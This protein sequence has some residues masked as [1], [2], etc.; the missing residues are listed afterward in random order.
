MAQY[1]QQT[2]FDFPTKKSLALLGG[3]EI[4]A[5]AT[6]EFLGRF[7]EDR[8]YERKPARIKPL[9]LQEWFSM[10]ANTP[11]GGLIA[12]GVADNGEMEGCS[13]LSQNQLNE[14]EKIKRLVPDA[15]H[16]SKRV[17]VL[18]N[19]GEDFIV[20]FRVRF[21]ENK[22]VDTSSGDAFIRL[23]GEKHLLTDD[24]RREIA[25]DKGQ[26]QFELEPAT[27]YKYPDDFDSKLVRLF[28]DAFRKDRGLVD[29]PT[30]EDILRM[31]HLGKIGPNGFEPNIAC[32]LLF[33]IDPLRL[34][35]AAKIQFIRYDGN[36]VGTGS[37]Y[38]V[39]KEKW[40]E[41]NVPSLIAEAGNFMESQIR[42]FYK[43]G[44]D[45]RF[46]SAPEYPREAWYESIVN[47]CAHR[48]YSLRNMTIFVRMFNN[49][50]EV[51]SP[52]G[53]PPFVTPENIY[54]NSNPRNRALMD[55]LYYLDFVRCANEGTKR[56]RDAMQAAALPAPVFEQKQVGFS[57]VRVTLKN[58]IEHR[59][60]YVDRDAVD[61]V[62][63]AIA[64][65]LD[66]IDRRIL[67]Y[68]AEFGK[69]NVTQARNQG[70]RDWHTAKKRLSDYPSE[71]YCAE[72]RGR[73]S[74]KTR[75]LTT[76]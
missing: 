69:I 39:V 46:E 24:E 35:P 5:H 26:L 28:A 57:Q 20:L 4:Y 34:I 8:R 6:Q 67:N 62:G 60:E 36:E 16:L 58:D 72:S 32:V 1:P 3:D 63:E 7:S 11:D 66:E 42:D 61:V 74:R 33:A 47:A 56:M 2:A 14:L 29:R 12:V 40:F 27:D 53:F 64:K 10:F 37:K 19:H 15:H 45:Q 50:I 25:A 44:K 59:R 9:V 51:A 22:V 54:D 52:G 71:G 65:T 49:R 21:N 48:S 70:L 30:D 31:R 73:I 75:M 41:G 43:L 17:A 13:C 23:G 55:A 76:F 68:V 18:T 38:N